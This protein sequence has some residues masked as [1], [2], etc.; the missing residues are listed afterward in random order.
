MATKNFVPR[1]DSEGQIGTSLKRWLKG[2]FVNLLVTGA[3]TDGFN[4]TSVSE[5]RQQIDFNNLMQSE[6]DFNNLEGV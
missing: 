1:S 2:V 3:V 6:I 4:I 5:I